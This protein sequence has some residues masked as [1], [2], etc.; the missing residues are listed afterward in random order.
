MDNCISVV[1]QGAMPHITQ[2]CAVEMNFGDSFSTYVVPRIP[3]EP[4]A[5]QTHGIVCDGT[6]VYVHGTEVVS[7]PILE[8]LSNFFTWLITFRKKSSDTCCTQ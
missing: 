1:R 5:E 2:S 8:A 4:G 3:S 6:S 7:F